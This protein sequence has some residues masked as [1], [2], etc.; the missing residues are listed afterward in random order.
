[1]DYRQFSGHMV[2]CEPEISFSQTNQVFRHREGALAMLQKLVRQYD[3]AVWIRF[4]GQVVS[5]LGNFMITP[6]ISLYLYERLHVSLMNTMLVASISPA[7]SLVSGFFAGPL[8]DRWGRKPLMCLSLSGQAVC[9]ALYALAHNALQ[10]AL[11]TVLEGIFE[12]FYWPSASAQ[13]TDVVPE[14][15]RSEVFALL[16]MGLNIGAAAG[17]LIGAAFFATSPRLLFWIAAGS[18]MLT[19]F[20]IGRFVPETKPT[21]GM[22]AAGASSAERDRKTTFRRTR[23]VFRRVN[24]RDY[25][26]VSWITL[27][28]LPITLLYAQVRTNLPLHLSHH[29]TN[30][31]HIYAIMMT[32]N[33]TCVIVFQMLV[34]RLTRNMRIWLLLLFAFTAFACVGF[35]YAWARSLAVLL[36][37]EFVF[38]VGEMIGFP[39]L[40]HAVGLLA[41]ADKRGKYFAIFGLRWTIG[42]VVGPLFGGWLM[43]SVGGAWMFT[44]V[45]IVIFVAGLLM[46]VTLRSRMPA[47]VVQTE[48]EAAL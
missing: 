2:H 12:S 32:F 18:T 11:V 40:Q 41:P 9:L 42:N 7:V 10:F 44:T 24:V 39:Q 17:P 4:L 19:T 22:D 8:T 31:T 15:K 21:R 37:T 43:R 46:V 29:F 30:Y 38:T 6:F 34:S 1:M 25:F 35:G 33:G 27:L 26:L 48:A 16:H 5:S 45:G 13:I 36:A 14:E 23:S 47:P 28:S 20:L 3:T